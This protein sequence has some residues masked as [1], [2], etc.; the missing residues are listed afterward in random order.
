LAV[1]PHVLIRGIEGN[2]TAVF[3]NGS[4][5]GHD[6]LRTIIHLP[7][8]LQVDMSAL[9][10]FKSKSVGQIYQ[11]RL[12]NAVSREIKLKTFHINIINFINKD[13]DQFIHRWFN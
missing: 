12:S 8:F 5:N 2:L 11:K 13:N 7:V 6:Y 9:E 4:V 3:R 10:Q 1:D